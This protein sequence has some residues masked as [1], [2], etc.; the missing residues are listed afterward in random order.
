MIEMQGISKTYTRPTGERVDALSEVSLTIRQG[1]FLAI[2]GSSGSGKST[3]LNV[4]GL[5]DVP[6]A[7]RYRF[8]G[9]DVTSLGVDAQARVRNRRIGFVFQSFHLLPRVSALENVE[10]PLLYSDRPSFDGLGRRALE[11]VGLQ[12]RLRHTP[13]ELSGGQQQR[14]AIARALV[15]EPDL[16]V[17]DEATGNLDERAAVEILAIFQALN[18]AGRTIV[19]VTHDAQVAKHATRICRIERGRIVSDEPVATPLVAAGE[20]R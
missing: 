13:S 7:G 15:N 8:D 3:L 10:L 11:A 12:D 5:L 20:G 9:D 18:R 4:L 14:V 19:L 17:A 1:E 16:L 6:T 2:V